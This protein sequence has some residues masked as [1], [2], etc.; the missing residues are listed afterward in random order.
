MLATFIYLLYVLLIFLAILAIYVVLSKNKPK[1]KISSANIQIEVENKQIK[2]TRAVEKNDVIKEAES[3]FRSLSLKNP[4]SPLPFKVLA[5]FYINNG[6][7]E[8]ALLKCQKMVNY[9]NKELDL[10]KLSKIVFFLEENNGL[11]VA[12]KIKTFYKEKT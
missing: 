3:H 10:E 2:K 8:E 4:Y 12:E 6:L 9:L 1:K 7:P 5:E 11:E